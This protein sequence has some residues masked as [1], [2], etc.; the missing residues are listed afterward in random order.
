MS[1][2]VTGGQSLPV[3]TRHENG[4]RTGD[5]FLAVY[6][7]SERMEKIKE[8]GGRW[9]MND[10]KIAIPEHWAAKAASGRRAARA[11]LAREKHSED[12]SQLRAV[13]YL[14]TAG[15]RRIDR[16]SAIV[17]QQHACQRRAN[18]LGATVVGEFV[19]FGSGLIIERPE[20]QRMLAELKERCGRADECITY[21]I[22]YDH[23]RIA[24]DMRLYA[25]VAWDIEQAG[26][27]LIVASTPL[28]EYEAMGILN[29]RRDS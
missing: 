3:T 5:P 20:L 26:A 14:R 9:A 16:E 19:D 6:L 29:E 23:A 15:A 1:G 24:R 17:A 2:K 10:D 18:E 7:N 4:I 21:V 27:Q 22:A 28:D 8:K 11:T 25:H 13:L 12:S